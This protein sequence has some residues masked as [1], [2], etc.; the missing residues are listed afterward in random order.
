MNPLITNGIEPA[1]LRGMEKQ[2]E[3]RD[4]DPRRKRRAVPAKQIDD[5]IEAEAGFETPKH[6]FDDLA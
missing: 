5:E 3:E 4:R 1:L 6:T 2:G